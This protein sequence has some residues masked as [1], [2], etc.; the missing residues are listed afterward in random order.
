MAMVWP[1]GALLMRFVADLLFRSSVLVNYS[2]YENNIDIM[3]SYRTKVRE[4][5]VLIL[6]P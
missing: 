4:N 5:S 1:H 3:L 6:V 2:F